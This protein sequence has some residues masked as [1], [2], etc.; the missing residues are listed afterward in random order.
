MCIKLL[1]YPMANEIHDK[2][3]M[4][5]ICIVANSAFASYASTAKTYKQLYNPKY[6]DKIYTS[7]SHISFLL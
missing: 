3:D 1:P 4:N 7:A 2:I 6:L 5:T